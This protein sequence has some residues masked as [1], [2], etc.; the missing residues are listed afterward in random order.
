MNASLNDSIA[1]LLKI[2]LLSAAISIGIKFLPFLE[3]IPVS[4]SLA[5]FLVLMPSLLIA[6][7]LLWRSR[8]VE[9]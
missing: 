7:L 2:L 1:V 5:L 9:E 3:R 8:R 4:S 6:A